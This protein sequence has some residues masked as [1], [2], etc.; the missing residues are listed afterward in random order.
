MCKSG[1]RTW[2]MRCASAM[3]SSAENN[4]GHFFCGEGYFG[5]DDALVASLRVLS[6]L[7]DRGQESPLPISKK[8]SNLLRAHS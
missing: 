5:F 8:L 2:S 7:A 1:A 4:R 6:I 3:H